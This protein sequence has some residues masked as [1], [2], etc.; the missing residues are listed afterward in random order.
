[1]RLKKPP[2][3]LLQAFLNKGAKVVLD[4]LNPNFIHSLERVDLVDICSPLLDKAKEKEINFM[5][6]NVVSCSAE[7]IDLIHFLIEFIFLIQ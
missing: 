6:V 3:S 5:N 4:Y 7:D 1:M 2:D